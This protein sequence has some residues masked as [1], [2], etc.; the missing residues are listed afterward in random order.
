MSDE[1]AIT[2]AQT[3]ETRSPMHLAVFPILALLTDAF[4]VTVAFW[5]AYWLRFTVEVVPITKDLPSLSSYVFGFLAALAIWLL[6]LARS[7]LYQMAQMRC[8]SDQL[9]AILKVGAL[10]FLLFLAAAFFY[11][12][13]SYSRL[14]IALSWILT[15]LLLAVNRALVIRSVSRW[16]AA[17]GMGGSRVAVVGNG[18]QTKDIVGNI[19]YRPPPGIELVGT[20]GSQLEED[21]PTSI[22]V[23]YLGDIDALGHLVVKHRLDRLIITIPFADHRNILSVLKECARYKLRYDIVP[24]LFGML[25]SGLQVTDVG[26]VP[27]LVFRARPIDGWGAVAKRVTD[28]VISALGLVVLGP[29]LAIISGM[30]VRDSGRP[31][32]YRQKRIGLDN[33]LFTM[34]KFRT[35]KADAEQTSGPVWATPD[36]PRRTRLGVFLRR[37]N[38]DELPQLWNVLKGQMSLVGPR[39][40]RPHFVERFRDEV[41][42]YLE[43]HRV[44]AGMTGWAQINGLRG[45]TSIEERTRY[46]NYYVE[47]WSLWFDLKILAR[48]VS[49]SL[50][51]EN[52]Y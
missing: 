9:A 41:P 17:K 50:K 47:N 21:E 49:A 44:K 20:I 14:M 6:L 35:M 28:I 37:T 12:D 34:N 15:L 29:L 8:L 22:P 31:V 7:G 13:E 42:R 36:D 43:R 38:L 48:T 40:E 24:D 27:L 45:N 46:D 25:T 3:K 1:K 4:W 33:R 52:A 2:L 16:L 11:R 23:T 39:P 5:A 18:P 19:S 32:L 10:S 30:I 26:G 51:G